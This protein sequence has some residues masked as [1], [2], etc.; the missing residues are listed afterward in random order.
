MERTVTEIRAKEA[1]GQPLVPDQTTLA[2]LGQ[3]TAPMP[4]ATN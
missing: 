4:V 2:R 1:S 3:D